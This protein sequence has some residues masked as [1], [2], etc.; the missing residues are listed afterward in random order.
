MLGFP[1][2][3]YLIALGFLVIGVGIYLAM[4][5][6][7][8]SQNKKIPLIVHIVVLT[9]LLWFT[10][11]MRLELFSLLVPLFHCLQYLLITTYFR[12][13]ELVRSGQMATMP[14]L[15]FF[16]SG[17]FWRYYILLV[18]F[19]LVFF[20][21]IP[22]LLAMLKV[23]K[24][25]FAYAVVYSFVNLHHFILDGEIWKLRKPDIGKALLT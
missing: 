15:S 11:G 20:N 19:G 1:L 3:A 8:A 5:F 17:Y 12:Y 4:S 6:Y 10:L 2:W 21:G 18:I 24:P 13:Q 9:Q 7:L 14:G 16:K 23:S 25:E 22:Q